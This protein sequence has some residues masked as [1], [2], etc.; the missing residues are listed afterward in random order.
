MAN[1]QAQTGGAQPPAMST[2][3]GAAMVVIILAL[4]GVIWS[5]HNDLKDA[6]KTMALMSAKCVK[7]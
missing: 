2:I 3:G 5:Q 7:K 6:V 1:A 4:T